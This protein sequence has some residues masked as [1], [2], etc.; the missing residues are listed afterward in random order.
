MSTHSH[1]QAIAAAKEWMRKT[2]GRPCD[3]TEEARERYHE[4]LGMLIDFLWTL[5]PPQP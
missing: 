3:L 2:Y 5:H 1:E 4:K